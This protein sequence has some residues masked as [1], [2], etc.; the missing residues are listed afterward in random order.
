MVL[1]G[2]WS[3]DGRRPAHLGRAVCRHVT[4]T[5]RNVSLLSRVS[6]PGALRRRPAARPRPRQGDRAHDRGEVRPASSR[7]E[8]RATVPDDAV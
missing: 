7:S 4:S 3:V 5:G 8:P 1:P 2:Q 6:R